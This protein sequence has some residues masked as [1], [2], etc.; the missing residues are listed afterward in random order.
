MSFGFVAFPSPAPEHAE[1]FAGRYPQVIDAGRTR[2]GLLRAEN[3]GAPGT[4]AVVIT[5]ALESEDACRASAET[6]HELGAAPTASATGRS[7]PAR[8]TASY[9]GDGE[10]G[11]V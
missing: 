7:S 9:R 10:A 11:H 2:P 4:D 3:W 5:G 8:P 1:E 6:V